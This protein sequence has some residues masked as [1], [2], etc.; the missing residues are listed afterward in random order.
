M[1][2]TNR[3]PESRPKR[4]ASIPVLISLPTWFDSRQDG[5][6][7][8]NPGLLHTPCQ[9]LDRHWHLIGHRTHHRSRAGCGQPHRGPDRRPG[10]YDEFQAF[11]PGCSPVINR[12]YPINAARSFRTTQQGA[13]LMKGLM[14]ISPLGILG[15]DPSK[16]H[17]PASRSRA[18]AGHEN[19]DDGD[20]LML[21]HCGTVRAGMIR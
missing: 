19:E 6:R 20:C 16:S 7:I 15:S 17:H 2:F 18:E 1:Q 10:A 5:S 21:K 12:S 3:K 13:L 9:Q 4:D 8:P 11:L 14:R